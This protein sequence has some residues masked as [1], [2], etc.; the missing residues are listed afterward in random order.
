MCRLVI[1]NQEYDLVNYQNFLSVSFS[2]LTFFNKHNTCC[3]LILN[4]QG[5]KVNLLDKILKTILKRRLL[6]LAIL[7]L[8]ENF[9]FIVIYILNIVFLEHL[10]IAQCCIWY[11]ARRVLV[12]SFSFILYSVAFG[13][14]FFPCVLTEVSV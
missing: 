11:F 4:F 13:G 14:I 2:A 12:C 8:N 1:W 7:E 5:I 9:H 10:C 6:V 3:S